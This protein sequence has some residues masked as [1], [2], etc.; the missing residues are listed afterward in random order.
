MGFNKKKSIFNT[1]VL[2]SADGC[3]LCYKKFICKTFEGYLR[4]LSDYF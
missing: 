3:I 2:S 4:F 1:M